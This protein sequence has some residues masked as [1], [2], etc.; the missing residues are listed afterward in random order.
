M[1]K[2]TKSTTRLGIIWLTC[3]VLFNP[4]PGWASEG[5]IDISNK[6]AWSENAGWLNF[7]PT[8]AGVTAHGTYLSGYAWAENIGWVKLGSGTGP[9]DNNS[10]T[11]WGVNRDSGTGAL[12]GYAWSEIAGWV[13]FNSTN[14]QVITN[15]DTGSFDG[16]AWS[17]NVGWVHFKYDDPAYNV[18]VV[19]PAITS[20]TPSSGGTDT[21]VTITGT[22]FTGT[23]AVTFGGTDAFSFNVYSFTQIEAIVA[24]GS[25]G[26]VTVTTPGGTATSDD[27]FTYS[28]VTARTYY[29]DIESGNDSNAGT[30]AAP[31][32][33]LH[34]AINQINGG[35]TGTSALPYTLNVALGTYS[36]T[37]E[38]AD[39]GLTIT[40]D[41]VT[42]EGASGSEPTIDGS[43]ATSWAYGIKISGSNVT[44]R[45]L[46]V[47]GFT[48]T[49][50]EGTG[51]E[52]ISGSNN[53]VENCRVY[54]NHNGISVSDSSNCTIQG[55]QVDNNNFDGISINGSAGGVITR[56]SIYDNFETDNSDGIIVEAC[57]PEISRNTIYDNRFN[58][59]LQ[60]SSTTPTSPTIKNNL[61]YES[62][63]DEVHYGIYV[64]GI[65]GSTVHPQIYHNTID[66][67]LYQGILIEGTGDTPI[68]KY[69]IVTNCRQSGIQNSGSPTIDYNDVWHNGPDPYDRNY[70]GCTAGANGISQDPQYASY[71]LAVTSPCI[72]A[73]PTGN[74]PDDPVTVDFDGDARPYGAGFDMGAYE[75]DNLPAV[76]T[77]AASSITA[78][79]ASSGGAVTSAGSET[80]VTARGVCWSTSA[81]PTTADS[82][83]TDGTGTGTFTSSITGLSS[84][85][86]YYSSGHMT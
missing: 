62:T 57:S 72:N 3:F 77:T 2:I 32:K 15:T 61:I 71:T 27:S 40:Q 45:N 55:C 13:N 6:Y 37:N 8:D 60:G 21:S 9:Y 49:S 78:T 74:P 31:W 70:D 46:Y 22:N 30:A 29:V 1:T 68:I 39:T 11:N 50:P 52:I 36:T 66:G 17:E 47:T 24:G 43:G 19:A 18:V 35:A 75:M 5:N 69:N 84:N 48:G 20:F 80:S 81:D 54:G 64:G 65:T 67:S 42:V 53:T 41:Y 56:N 26:T 23:T 58:I 4:Q 16:Y 28:A 76:S 63:L 73:I 85:T 44:L 83:T 12:S 79:S 34:H 33:T 86:T 10:S 25:T 51:I 7:R 82:K 59:S 14:S 38:E